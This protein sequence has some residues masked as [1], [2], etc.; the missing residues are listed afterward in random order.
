MIPFFN[1]QPIKQKF[2]DLSRPIRFGNEATSVGTYSPDFSQMKVMGKYIPDIFP[3]KRGDLWV[4]TIV[5]GFVWIVGKERERP[6]APL[7]YKIELSC[8]LIYRLNEKEIW[9]ERMEFPAQGLSPIESKR[10]KDT[11]I[12]DELKRIKQNLP[13]QYEYPSVFLREVKSV[14]QNNGLIVAEPDILLTGLS[15]NL[16]HWFV[17]R[18]GSSSTEDDLRTDLWFSN[19]GKWGK[20]ANHYLY[21]KPKGDLTDVDFLKN[22]A[23]ILLPDVK[24]KRIYPN[25]AD[26]NFDLGRYLIN[27]MVRGLPNMKYEPDGASWRKWKSKGSV[28]NI[29]HL[30]TNTPAFPRNMGME[31]E[32]VLPIIRKNPRRFDLSRKDAII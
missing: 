14:F 8:D 17:G 23:Y 3:F 7:F 5:P 13:G 30:I 1:I 31:L 15:G 28:R 26:N 16:F 6:F 20:R 9:S 32:D 24:V 25:T 21:Y 2:I 19:R 27:K 22:P 4:W 18:L 12:E 29:D 11:K 10:I